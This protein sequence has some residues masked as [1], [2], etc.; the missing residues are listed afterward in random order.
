MNEDTQEPVSFAVEPEF[1]LLVGGF[2]LTAVVLVFVFF[3]IRTII[4]EERSERQKSM[5]S[6]GQSNE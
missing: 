6:D 2:F 1:V 5:K 4:R 3:L